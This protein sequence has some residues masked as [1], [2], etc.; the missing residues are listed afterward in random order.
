MKKIKQKIAFVIGLALS[1]GVV[2]K[3]VP[4]GLAV[5]SVKAEETTKISSIGYTTNIVKNS[6]GEICNFSILDE[7]FIANEM[8]TISQTKQKREGYTYSTSSLSQVLSNENN[9]FAGRVSGGYSGVAFS[10]DITLACSNII[11]KAKEKVI[12]QYYYVEEA[13]CVLNTEMLSSGN[14]LD[15]IATYENDLNDSFILSLERL[16]NG[17][18]TYNEFFNVCGTH[19]IAG[20]E[21]GGQ[22]KTIYGIY[23]ETIAYTETEKSE[24]DIMIEATK[25]DVSVGGN[26]SLSLAEGTNVTTANSSVISYFRAQGGNGSFVSSLNNGN[27]VVDSWINSITEENAVVVD[28]TQNGLL[29]IWDI[30]PTDYQSLKIPMENAFEQYIQENSNSLKTKDEILNGEAFDVLVDVRNS[31]KTFTDSDRWTNSYDTVNIGEALGYN[32]APLLSFGYTSVKVKLT[33]Q[34]KA[35]DLAEYRIV[36]FYRISDKNASANELFAEFKWLDDNKSY[37]EKTLEATIPLNR[38]KDNK[39]YIRY[40]A[41]GT[42][43]DDWKNKEVK[44]TLTF[45]K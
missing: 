35:V 17:A 26:M 14:V 8:H 39:F 19:M 44:V 42:W 40:R 33:M 12:S 23:S 4:L 27:N 18:L 24:I 22:F 1:V 5:S 20:I 10:A 41:T 9:E 29:P 7:D 32:V 34:V 2:G 3:C 21:W 43:S 6:I 38:I 28:Y 37:K 36:F 45:T 16:K 31:E 30:L 11:E 13:S 15:F 25:S